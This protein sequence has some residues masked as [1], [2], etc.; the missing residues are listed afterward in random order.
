M[1]IAG[2]SIR[3]Y[4]D[5]NG[6]PRL[7]ADIR[8]AGHDAIAAREVSNCELS[9]ANQLWWATSN[10]RGIVTYDLDDF[11]MLA[12]MWAREG[13]DH[14]GITLA[15]QPPAVPYGEM[16]RRLLRLLDTLTADEMVNRIEWLDDRWSNRS[17]ST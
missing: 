17:D 6:N 4:F 11:P 15:R 13:H 8:G 2:L 16:L 3:L 14:A 1:A 9:D 12:A 7:A 10:G 5:H